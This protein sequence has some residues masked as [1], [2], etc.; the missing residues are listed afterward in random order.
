M[1]ESAAPAVFQE[2]AAQRPPEQPGRRR[3]RFLAVG[4]IAAAVFAVLALAYL[5]DWVTSSGKVPRGVDVAGVELGG[6]ST[7]DADATLRARI[8]SR[9]D[10][11]LNATAGSQQAQIVPKDA[12]LGVDWDATLDRVGSQP[13]N[14]ITRITSFFTHRSVDLVP[15]VDKFALTSAV[16]KLRTQV[17]RAPV[18][19]NVRFEGAKAVGVQPVDGQKLD[20]EGAKTALID[21]WAANADLDLPVTTT[22]VTVDQAAV[23]KAVAEVAAPAVANDLVF[24]GKNGKNATLPKDQVGTVLTFA[25]DGNGG[26]APQYNRDAATAILAPQLKPTEIEPKDASISLAGG[27][28]RVEP[29]VVGDLVQWQKT[30]DPLPALLKA[31]AP[32]TVA[33][34]Y[35]PVPPKLTTE[36]ASGLGIKEVVSEFTTG[37]F[38][39]ASGVNIGLVAKE[40]NGAIVKPGEVFSLNGF[41]GPRGEAQGYVASGIIDK[42]RPSKAVGGG[43]SQFATTLYNASYFAGLEDVEHTEHSYY[44]SRYPEAREATVFEGAIDLK[45][46]NDTKSGILIESYATDSNVTVRMWSTKTM[47]VK[48]STG[49]RTKPT[50]PDTQTLPKGNDCIASKG[51]PGFTASNTRT[52][53]DIASGQQVSSRTRTVKYDPVPIVKC[54]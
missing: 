25:P 39:P 50:E 45:F 21:E 29:A 38:E 40:V 30:L 23:D 54:E 14:P 2:S 4:L 36:A 32:R 8:A 48:S 43:I 37:G 42:G 24:T 26:L 44:I 6:K 22:E 18:E 10:R 27:T 31:P 35:E 47:D 9:V 41:T 11:P 28:P 13:I 5:A 7:D 3:R 16:D 52:I 49:D 34:V 17:D 33:A 19:G 53:T 20:V 51:A 15:A 46:R 12:G 1:E